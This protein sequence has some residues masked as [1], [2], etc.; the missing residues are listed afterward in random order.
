MARVYHTSTKIKS[1][2]IVIST[3]WGIFYASGMSIVWHRH[4]GHID[5]LRSL[6][7][8]MIWRQRSTTSCLLH[9]IA[10]YIEDILSCNLTS[11]HSIE[12]TCPSIIV[13]KSISYLIVSACKSHLHTVIRWYTNVTQN[14]GYN[15]PSEPG[16]YFGSDFKSGTTVRGFT[17]K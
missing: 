7:I 11:F 12:R 15:Q 13:E 8:R 10:F 17:I 5:K 2:R 4:S 1:S 16:F 9:L 14:V 3:I 6:K